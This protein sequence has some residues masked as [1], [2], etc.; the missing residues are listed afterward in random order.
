MS[1]KQT[2]PSKGL[3]IPNLGLPTQTP[4]HTAVPSGN[5]YIATT[6]TISTMSSTLLTNISPPNSVHMVVES[7]LPITGDERVILSPT[8]S[9][10]VAKSTSSK[11]EDL[12]LTPS[13]TKTGHKPPP[14]RTSHY[15]ISPARS[16]F[17]PPSNTGIAD[18]IG[19]NPIQQCFRTN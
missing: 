13:N 3:P 9:S 4:S 15:L 8:P 14:I 12:S 5:P 18:T 19:V 17:S 10:V 7:V 16:F 6:N 1:N 11:Q 2:T